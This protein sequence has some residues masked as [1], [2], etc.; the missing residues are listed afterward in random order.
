MT[1]VIALMGLDGT[2]KTTL[3]KQTIGFFRK[4]GID[5]R[6]KHLYDCVFTKPIIRLV[7][8]MRKPLDERKTQSRAQRHHQWWQYQLWYVLLWL[9]NLMLYVF[10]S[11]FKPRSILIFD[12]YLYDT[13]IVSGFLNKSLRWLFLHFAS[14]HIPIILVADSKTLRS[15][16]KVEQEIERRDIERYFH[17]ARTLKIPVLETT[18]PLELT[19]HHLLRII[20][21]HN[22]LRKRFIKNC[23]LNRVLFHILFAEKLYEMHGDFRGILSAVQGRYVTYKRLIANISEVFEKHK[24]EWAMKDYSVELV[25]ENDLDIMVDTRDHDRAMICL[26]PINSSIPIHVRS[27]LEAYHTNSGR[28]WNVKVKMLSKGFVLKNIGENRFVRLSDILYFK[29]R[30]GLSKDT[31]DPVEKYVHGLIERG[32]N[33]SYPHFLPFSVI[34]QSARLSNSSFFSVVLCF[35]SALIARFLYVVFE[36]FFSHPTHFSRGKALTG[37]KRVKGR[38]IK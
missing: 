29:F 7:K 17:L 15:R 26:R 37:L 27:G 21:K 23:E 24:I 18:R 1:I 38:L 34:L 16:K 22:V 14:P 9:D 10:Y 28:V 2:G 30:G 4:I 6:Y 12:R 13:P 8:S 36:E 20:F 19:M 31:N 33:I 32:G 25:P 3:A 5:V 35:F 11:L